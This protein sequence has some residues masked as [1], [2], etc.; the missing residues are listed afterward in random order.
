MSLWAY[1]HHKYNPEIKESLL[2][3]H[4]RPALNKNISF[5]KLFLFDNN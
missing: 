4:D 3:K 1:G 5:A 2:T